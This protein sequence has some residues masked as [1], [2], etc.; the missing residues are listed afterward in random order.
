MNQSYNEAIEK[1]AHAQGENIL[2]VLDCLKNEIADA[3]NG[4]DD[5]ATRKLA[6]DMIDK[7]LYNVIKKVL[8]Q[9]KTSK[10]LEL[11]EMI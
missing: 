11:D 3:R 8:T 6:I 7:K 2:F 9:K 1:I 5:V 4:D 10:D